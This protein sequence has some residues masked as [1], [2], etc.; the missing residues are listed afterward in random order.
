VVGEPQILGQIKDA[1]DIATQ[2]K[3]SGLILHRL[4]HRAF[5]V[6][7]RVRTETKN[8][9]QRCLGQLGRCGAGQENL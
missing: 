9:Q 4:L 7:K 2:T 8:Q 6:A 3:T 1:Y 5:H